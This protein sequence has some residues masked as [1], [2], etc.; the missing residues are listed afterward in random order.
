M[1]RVLAITCCTGRISIGSRSVPRNVGV[2]EVHR[3]AQGNRTT[4]VDIDSSLVGDR[5]LGLIVNQ[6]AVQIRRE[7]V[8]RRGGEVNRTAIDGKARS[9]PSNTRVTPVPDGSA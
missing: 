4:A 9:V 3:A 1:V 8:G 5:V 6:N 2:G 7:S